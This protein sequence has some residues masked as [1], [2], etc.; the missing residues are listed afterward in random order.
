MRT[1]TLA[2]LGAPF[3]CWALYACLEIMGIGG[4]LALAVSIVWG[5][6]WLA[7]AHV[8]RS[9]WLTRRR[10]TDLGQGMPG[11]RG[12]WTGAVLGTF[13]LPIPIALLSV[14]VE[15]LHIASA[16]MML[17]LFTMLAVPVPSALWW[18]ALW[19]NMEQPQETLRPIG[20]RQRT[21]HAPSGV[22][23]PRGGAWREE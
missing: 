13:F 17:P 22:I 1:A 19:P 6:V 11:G 8:G 18:I 5:T 10:R 12:V 21:P 15:W 4:T 20:W 16:S 2:I 23:P 14:L 3:A 7:I 9:H